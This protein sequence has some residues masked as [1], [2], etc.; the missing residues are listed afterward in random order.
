[1]GATD[2]SKADPGTLRRELGTSIE[3]NVTHGSDA[4]ETA[5]VEIGYFFPGVA[6]ADSP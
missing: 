4:A 5:A 6:F 3:R 1:M 2:P